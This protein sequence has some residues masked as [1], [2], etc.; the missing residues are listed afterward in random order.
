[1][2]TF[3]FFFFKSACICVSGVSIFEFFSIGKVALVIDLF[4]LF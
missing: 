3:F 2:Y 4:S 1:M